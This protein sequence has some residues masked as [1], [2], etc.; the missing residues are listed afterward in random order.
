MKS[1]YS[2]LSVSNWRDVS[3]VFVSQ[4][5]TSHLAR[6]DKDKPSRLIRRIM[7]SPNVLYRLP[8]M[9]RTLITLLVKKF[10]G[11]STGSCAEIMN[12]SFNTSCYC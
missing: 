5:H 9:E 10:V 6:G 2:S 1:R 12:C 3:A 7:F 8:S 4:L 11:S